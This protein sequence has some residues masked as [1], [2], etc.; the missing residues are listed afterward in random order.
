MAFLGIFKS[1][2]T[3]DNIFDKDNGLLAKVGGWVGNN[4]L[5][6]EEI[7]ESNSATV[8]S[9]QN[10]VKATLSES[11]ARSVT[12]RSVA[13]N[14]IKVHLGFYL[15]SAVA[16]PWN[17]KLASFY[18]ELANSNLLFVGTSAIIIFFFGSHGLT[19][20]QEAKANKK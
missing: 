6:P 3:E 9:V 14:W 16:A 5:T 4:K 11:T 20:F 19:K 8:A 1:K 18:L 17:D 2:K 10:F 12:R 7:M 13:V 15:M